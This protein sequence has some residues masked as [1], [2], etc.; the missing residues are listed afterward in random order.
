MRIARIVLAVTLTAFVGVAA[1]AKYEA[2]AKPKTTF[3]ERWA[4]V[5]EALHSGGFRHQ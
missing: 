4:P 2:V 3:A 5:D 1:W